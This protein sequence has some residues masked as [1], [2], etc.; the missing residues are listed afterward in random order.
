VANSY[1]PR[2]LGEDPLFKGRGLA[3]VKPGHKV[4]P[5]QRDRALK[6]LDVHPCSD[7]LLERFHVQPVGALPVKGHCLAGDVQVRSRRPA[8]NGQRL[9]QAVLGAGLG[10]FSPQ[11]AGQ[12]GALVRPPGDGQVAQQGQRLAG[13]K[14]ADRHPVPAQRHVAQQGQ[15]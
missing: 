8:Q 14:V 3:H 9:A 12:R 4:A 7:A 13:A 10:Q 1:K 6:P 5:V 15:L 11:Q 2:A